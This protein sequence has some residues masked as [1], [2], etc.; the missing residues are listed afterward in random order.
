MHLLLPETSINS[1]QWRNRCNVEG[2]I[3]I[4]L[5]MRNMVPEGYE[6]EDKL[7]VSLRPEVSSMEDYEQV[8][9]EQFGKAMLRG[10]GWNKD[11]GIGGKNKQ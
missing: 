9:I 7:D 1:D 5:V 4:P 8:P 10:M 2:N 3:E 11:E 6:T